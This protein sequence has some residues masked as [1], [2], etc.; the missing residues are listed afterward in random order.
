MPHMNLVA[1]PEDRRA[2]LRDACFDLLGAPA[3]PFELPARVLAVR[4]EV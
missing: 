2:E 1:Q 4:G 3:G